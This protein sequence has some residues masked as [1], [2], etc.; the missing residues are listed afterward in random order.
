M[1]S[2]QLDD[3][4]AEV[5]QEIKHDVPYRH[6]SVHVYLNNRKSALGIC[7]NTINGYIIEV[8]KYLLK[9]LLLFFLFDIIVLWNERFSTTNM[10][11]E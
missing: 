4:L 11:Q 2:L 1:N 5:K 7:K 9:C 3:L 8:S 6:D 10:I